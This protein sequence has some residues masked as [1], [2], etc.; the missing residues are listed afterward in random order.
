MLKKNLII[1]LLLPVV[2]LGGEYSRI[3]ESSPWGIVAVWNGDRDPLDIWSP[4]EYWENY[5]PQIDSSINCYLS[6]NRPNCI[7]QSYYLQGSDGIF[8]FEEIDSCVKF[9]QEGNMNT[10]YIGYPINHYYYVD[11][12]EG[13]YWYF[14]IMVE[15]YDGDGEGIY[16]TVWDNGY[17]DE[18]EWLKKPIKYWNISN[19]PYSWRTG[20]SKDW[21]WG[22]PDYG[23]RTIED[24]RKFVRV[25]SKGIRDADREAQVVA[26][27][28][29]PL[30]S[31]W[32]T[33]QNMEND[34]RPISVTV[35]PEELDSIR[36]STENIRI[37]FKITG[38]TGT[39][40]SVWID[41]VWCQSN[42]IENYGFE[43]GDLSDWIKEPAGGG[44]P[45]EVSTNY[46]REGTYSLHFPDVYSNEERIVQRFPLSQIEVPFMASCWVKTEEL[47]GGFRI[48]VAFWD[49]DST[50]YHCPVYSQ[51]ITGT[52]P[53]TK[54]YV[55]VDPWDIPPGQP[56]FKVALR[57]YEG[58]GKLWVDDVWCQSNVIENYSFEDS[59]NGWHLW[60]PSHSTLWDV[61][62]DYSKEG[63]YSL[64][65]SID[66]ASDSNNRET[67]YQTI[68]ISEF[69][70]TSKS[71][72]VSCYVKDSSLYRGITLEVHAEGPSWEDNY[73][74]K[75]TPIINS[76]S[77][78][79]DSLWWE[80]FRDGIDTCIDIISVHE[81]WWDR[82]FGLN[83]VQTSLREID[84][85]KIILDNLGLGNKPI[86][87]TEGGITKREN[88]T[89]R[90]V[91]YREWAEGILE[92]DWFTK[93]FFFCMKDYWDDDS[94][95]WG[96]LN[97]DW[98]HRPP[99]D[100]LKSFIYRNTPYINLVSPEAGDTM[101]GGQYFEIIYD[102]LYDEENFNPSSAIS[103]RLEYSIDGGWNYAVIDS[104]LSPTGSY[105][106]I[107]PSLESDSCKLR[108]LA[109]DSD[110]LEGMS[111][112][113]GFFTIKS[114]LQNDT[115]R[116]GQ[117]RNYW[118]PDSMTVA[119]NS[120]YFVIE[121]NDSTGGNVTMRAGN[122]ISLSPGF[123]GQTGC[124][125]EAYID[126]SL[127]PELASFPM[128][129]ISLIDIFR[130]TGSKRILSKTSNKSLSK[131]GRIP[132]VFSCAQ[133]YPNPFAT[134]T[135]IK[136]GL[137]KDVKV[138]LDI[139]NL[140]GQKVR[141]LVDARQSAGYKSVSWNG[142]TSTGKEAP[143]GVYFY[144]FKAG[145]FEK[146]RKMILIK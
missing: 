72:K 62:S 83:K 30:Q 55:T 128:K 134:S 97:P 130:T 76:Y 123:E 70:D 140:I 50:S 115:V 91:M 15:R 60:G 118:S 108:V 143:Q 77:L 86:W 73:G 22:W 66:F 85:M 139:Y 92:R 84:S 109:R 67:C 121:G 96:I 8:D 129:R 54:I 23:N 33:S 65:H 146:H 136:Y 57:R 38:G 90:G 14:R 120:A 25:A 20:Y 135:I 104:N 102:S 36:D 106:W 105:N 113:Y 64:Y 42:N 47:T 28:I 94:D 32:R 107:P 124:D 43:T 51:L 75:T 44:A 101:S 11:S 24:F 52:N 7:P 119:G 111:T 19:E 132:K 112:N 137:P 141:T 5:M 6:W 88:D 1:L 39:T 100:T 35:K 26:P 71:F 49:T 9:L 58:S 82:Y 21:C 18:P 79:P 114:G 117:T 89:E 74:K 59:L 99:Y 31:Y 4:D 53:W 78:S 69:Q 81:Y 142:L 122:E 13:Y 68:P 145:D 41:N 93:M 127:N 46:S 40:G 125:F 16:D 116:I 2:I 3:T 48:E 95:I 144:T 126:P 56:N 61:K 138:Q 29:Q 27:S 131:E 80:I 34:W 10:L 98:T 12:L 45:W 133:N 37:Q 87:F 110:G 17:V 63:D 103:I